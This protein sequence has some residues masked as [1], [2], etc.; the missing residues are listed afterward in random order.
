M[1]FFYFLQKNS[2]ARFRRIT[3]NLRAGLESTKDLA[4]CEDEVRESDG[5][6]RVCE[7]RYSRRC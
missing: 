2:I 3:A 7:P 4:R 1:L 5:Y 6:F